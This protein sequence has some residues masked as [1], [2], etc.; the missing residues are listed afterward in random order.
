MTAHGKKLADTH[1]WIGTEVVS[2]P[3]GDSNSEWL[4][5][6]SRSGPIARRVGI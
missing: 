2:S 4:S 6:S 5:R 3:L 1:A